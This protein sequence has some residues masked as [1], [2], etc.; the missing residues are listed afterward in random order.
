M[1]DNHLICDLDRVIDLDAGVPDCAFTLRMAEQDLDESEIFCSQV[2]QSG[3]RP[4][5]QVRF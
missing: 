5:Q 1:S 2:D 3:L 4:T